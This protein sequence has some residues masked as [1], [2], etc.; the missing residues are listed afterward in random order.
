MVSS[1]CVDNTTFRKL[2]VD[3]VSPLSRS[4]SPHYIVMWTTNST[5]LSGFSSQ[6]ANGA[7]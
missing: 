3:S 4:T 5:L 1:S 7:L 6:E 2:P